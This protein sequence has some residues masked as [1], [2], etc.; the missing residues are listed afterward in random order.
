M[1]GIFHLEE[2]KNEHLT[3]VA[4]IRLLD[5]D[6]SL[7][8]QMI[9][10][11]IVTAEGMDES[12]GSSMAGG[13]R[14]SETPEF[15]RFFRHPSVT[16]LSKAASGVGGSLLDTRKPKRQ[17]DIENVSKISSNGKFYTEGHYTG[18]KPN[19][20]ALR[21]CI[22]NGPYIPTT[23]EVQDVATTDESLAVL[24]HTIVETLMNMS[25]ENKAHFESEKEA[26]HLILTGIGDEI[27]STVDAYQT[28]QEM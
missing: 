7:K 28:A 1:A 24:E 8:F 25:L 9:L 23:V 18:R 12:G 26:M 11:R 13:T 2:A 16:T 3:Y 21:K 14:A 6:L 17:V 22:L 10:Q 27:Y 15:K 20:D 4:H 19:G 5:T